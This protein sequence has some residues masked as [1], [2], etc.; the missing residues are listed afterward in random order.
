M[1]NPA[2][3]VEKHRLSQ[4]LLAARSSPAALP[5]SQIKVNQAPAEISVPTATSH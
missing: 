3:K 2:V 1:S 4:E 5:S